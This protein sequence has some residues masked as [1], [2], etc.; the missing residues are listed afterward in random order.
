[1]RARIRIETICLLYGS[2]FG[3][4]PANAGT[5]GFGANEY[6]LAEK[7]RKNALAS[8]SHTGLLVYRPRTHGSRPAEYEKP[9]TRRG[10]SSSRR[11]LL[12]ERSLIA[13]AG[14]TTTFTPE[15]GSPSA[16]RILPDTAPV[17]CNFN[18]TSDVARLHADGLRLS[19]R[20]IPIPLDSKGVHSGVHTVQRE[21][22]LR[23]GNFTEATLMIA[24]KDDERFGDAFA[25]LLVDGGARDGACLGRHWRILLTRELRGVAEQSR[26]DQQAAPPLPGAMIE[27]CYAGWPDSS[28]YWFCWLPFAPVRRKHQP[29]PRTTLRSSFRPR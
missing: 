20:D 29:I 15:I 6:A 5:A 13:R 22:A 12:G 25:R 14:K 3:I 1:M 9:G 4:V 17:R 2:V 7:V 8:R 24:P 28:A 27:P 10:R 18:F 23:V 26:R 11:N 19:A 16:S 21:L